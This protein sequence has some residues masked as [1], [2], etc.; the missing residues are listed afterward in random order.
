[1]SGKTLHPCDPRELNP[2]PFDTVA[3]IRRANEATADRLERE[4]GERRGRWFGTT[5]MA[6]FGTRIESSVYGGRYFV[7]S[8]QPPSGP[9]TFNVRRATD[10]GEVQSIGPSASDGIGSKVHAVDVAADLGALETGGFLVALAEWPDPRQ[11]FADDCERCGE[12]ELR[13]LDRPDEADF[14]SC[15]EHLPAAAIETRHR[16]GERTTLAAVEGR[17]DNPY[18]GHPLERPDAPTDPRERRRIRN[19]V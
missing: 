2:G 14:A 1:M 11:C 16:Y 10:T 15:A 5:E 3:D 18:P 8:E 17:F 13:R 19:G 6:F 7:T 9:R 12:Y 4:T